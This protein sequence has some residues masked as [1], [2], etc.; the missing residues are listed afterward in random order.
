MLQLK[1]KTLSSSALTTLATYQS[2]INAHDHYPDRVAEA[3]KSWDNLNRGTKAFREIKTKLIDMCPPIEHC[4][5]CED[6]KAE[7]IE[8]FRPKSLYPDLTFVWENYLLA[9][10]ACNSTSK[11]DKFSVIDE[12][13]ALHPLI[14]TGEEPISGLPALINPRYENP[15]DFMQLEFREFNFTA[16]R[17][18]SRADYTIKTLQLNTRV[19]LVRWRKRA[20]GKFIKWLELYPIYQARGDIVEH[21]QELYEYEHLSV[22]EEMRRIYQDERFNE[23]KMSNPNLQKI[24]N[25]FANAPKALEIT[26]IPK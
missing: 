26:F 14:Y 11:K 6:G 10:S 23:L 16:Y 7:E 9:C 5:Y 2:K 4:C 25:G 3:K 1:D 8:H 18:N 22:W 19:E 17:E 20:F 13:G 12:N 15:M 24:D 21:I